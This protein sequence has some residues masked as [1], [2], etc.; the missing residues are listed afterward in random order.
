MKTEDLVARTWDDIVFEN[1]NKDYGA[2]SIRKSYEKSMM[3][4]LG[5]SVSLACLLIA[6]PSI[7]GLFGHKMDPIIPAMK[8]KILV[9]DLIDPPIIHTITPPPPPLPNPPPR[10]ITAAN[11]Q[12]TDHDVE[13]VEVT[14]NKDV[15]IE[16]PIEG[17]GTDVV[18]APPAIVEPPVVE[19]PVITGPVNVAEVMPTCNDMVRFLSRNL[20]YPPTA[21]RMR[22]SGKVFVGF[23]VN[24]EGKVIDVKVVKG[25]HPDCDKEAVRVVSMMPQWT[26]GMQ[27]KQA[28]AVRMVLPITFQMLE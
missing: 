8:E 10:E 16:Q 2:Y 21:R 24:K 28:V 12:I 4:G 3:T 27:N 23:V 18:I 6:L 26:P 19:P 22:I 15:I 25:I 13:E 5:V 1:R 14:P 7:V 20:R 11:I 9:T 17:N